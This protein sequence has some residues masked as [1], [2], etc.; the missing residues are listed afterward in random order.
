MVCRRTAYSLY[1]APADDLKALE[2]Q[3]TSIG[4]DS[5]NSLGVQRHLNTNAINPALCISHVSA[6]SNRCFLVVN[7]LISSSSTTS[8]SPNAL[9]VKHKRT[10]SLN[11]TAIVFARHYFF[12]SRSSYVRLFSSSR[13]FTELHLH[14]HIFRQHHFYHNFNHI[15]SSSA[16]FLTASINPVTGEN[17]IHRVVVARTSLR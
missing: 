5:L 4:N 15:I 14:Y 16:S 6:R 12:R 17:S 10:N 9:I 7:V 2:S 11:A 8:F 1:R 13:P 3:E